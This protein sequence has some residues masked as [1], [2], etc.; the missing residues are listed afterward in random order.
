MT[1]MR[2]G[3]LAA[4]I[5]AAS[6][7]PAA[8]ADPLTPGQ[9]DAVR[10]IVR[11]YLVENPEVLIEAL[12]AYE[13]KMAAE[14]QKQ[15]QATLAQRRDQ[16][17]RDPTSPVAGA[18]DGDV[19]LVEFTDYRCSYCKK[20][21]PAVQDLLKA[22][23]GIRYVVKEYPIL[24]PDS[25]VAAR[26]A[27]AVWRST[28]AE[29]MAFHAAL[30]AARGGLDETRVLEIAGEIGLD[31]KALAGAMKDPEI[32]AVLA[33]NH[34]L[35]QALNIRGTPAFVVG[36]RLVPGAVDVETLRRLVAEARTQ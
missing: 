22:D 24:G 4:L 10:Q 6:V 5:L 20:V 1:R 33:K 34:E 35:A 26:A 18:A 28:P 17:E 29:Y 30:M 9:A 36:G 21:F 7:F 15:Q 23:G 3:P 14:A 31:A 27:L 12:Q 11:E 2:L 19:T 25:V 32:N 16:L 8:A 13:S